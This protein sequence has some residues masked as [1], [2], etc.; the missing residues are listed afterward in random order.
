[1]GLPT[2]RVGPLKAAGELKSSLAALLARPPADLP[3]PIPRPSPRPVPLPA[4][5]PAPTGCGSDPGGFGFRSVS[6][7]PDRFLE[8][9]R[10]PCRI[11]PPH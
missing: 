3:R 9:S 7:P 1:L 10:L 2:A 11:L 5:R 4:P 8:E 6:S